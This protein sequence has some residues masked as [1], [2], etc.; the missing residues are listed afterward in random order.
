MKEA[1]VAKVGTEI[2]WDSISVLPIAEL[3]RTEETSVQA[4]AQICYNDQALHI[5]L[6]AIEPEIRK[7]ETGFLGM[8][9]NDSCLEFFFRPD[10]NDLRY[11]NF[12]FNPNGCMYLGLGSGPDNL[13]RLILDDSQKETGL[14]PVIQEFH[15]KWSITFQVP[16]FFIQQFFPAFQ[17]QNITSIRA[18]FYKCGDKLQHPHYLAWN[19]VTEGDS[20]F[21]HSP[22]EF[23][24]LHLGK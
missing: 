7:V 3:I 1:Y 4:F 23:G 18:N 8:P 6:T 11:F 24:F 17:I 15:D 16:Y 19:R 5:R 21:F 2:N 9:C 14:H 20:D 10:I 13:V 12:E 22:N